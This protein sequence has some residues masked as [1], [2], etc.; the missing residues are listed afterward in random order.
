MNPATTTLEDFYSKCYSEYHEIIRKYI[1]CRISCSYEAEDLMQDVFVRLWEHRAFVNRDTVRPLLF[2]IARNMVIDRI[3]LHYKK[4]EFTSYIYNVQETRQNI[5]E[6]QVQMNELMA[7]HENVL[8]SLPS[9]RRR[10]YTLHFYQDASVPVIA[11]KLN[12]SKRT[13]EGHL[14]LARKSIR[15]FIRQQYEKVG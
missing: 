3:R 7:L 6:D 1:A 5:T 8:R 2:T 14:F 11:D 15:S 10:I 13:V 12:L 9:K 4:E